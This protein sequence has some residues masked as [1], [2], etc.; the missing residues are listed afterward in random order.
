MK[1]NENT[2][3]DIAFFVLMLMI[4]AMI[5]MKASYAECAWCPSYAC[6]GP[7]SCGGQCVCVTGPG[8]GG[9]SCYSVE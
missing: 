1:R 6:Y 3:W 8:G 2:K 7:N 4:V 9:G 5:S